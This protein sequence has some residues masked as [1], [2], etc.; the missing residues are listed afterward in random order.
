MIAICALVITLFTASCSKDNNIPD[1]EKT[2]EQALNNMVG[3]YNGTLRTDNN[4]PQLSLDNSHLDN[5]QELYYY[6]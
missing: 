6:S 1:A 5:K 3:T 2:A 4:T